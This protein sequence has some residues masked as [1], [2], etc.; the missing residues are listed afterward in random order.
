MPIA[1]D[2]NGADVSCSITHKGKVIKEA[3]GEDTL[4]AGG[5]V[6]SPVAG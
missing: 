1:V 6:V 4:A 3:K 5:C 2:E